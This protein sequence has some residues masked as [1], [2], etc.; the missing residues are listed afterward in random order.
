VKSHH[1]HHHKHHH[2]HRQDDGA[3]PTDAR[4]GK[5]E[6][7]DTEKEP[8]QQVCTPAQMKDPA[9]K[10]IDCRPPKAKGSKSLAQI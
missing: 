3:A 7:D 6:D 1:R 2:K 5:T 10:G 8:E 9:V 4:S